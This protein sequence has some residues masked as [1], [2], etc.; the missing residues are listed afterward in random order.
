MIPMRYNVRSL[1]VRRTASVMTALVVMILFIPLGF[2]AGLQRTVLNAGNR[3]NWVV[4]SRGV[5]N[6][7]GSYITREQYEIIRARPE[8][9]MGPSGQA[10][11]SPW[12]CS[13]RALPWAPCWEEPAIYG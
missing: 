13:V 1:M 5:N 2:I 7:P 10:L 6:E 4:L 11:I 8:I 9:A 12:R 3:G